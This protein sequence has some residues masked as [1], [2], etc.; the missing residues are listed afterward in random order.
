MFDVTNVED[1][2]YLLK[3]GA[4]SKKLS[5]VG[6][7][8]CYAVTS[9][10]ECIILLLL[11]STSIGKN[12]FHRS[13]GYGRYVGIFSCLS[14]YSVYGQ[15]LRSLQ[16]LFLHLHILVLKDIISFLLIF[17]NFYYLAKLPLFS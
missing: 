10:A 11:C 2:K 4:Q 12:S 17:Q 6:F 16:L 1:Q 9:F 8:T 7:A 3:N 15:L 5:S 13:W 14:S